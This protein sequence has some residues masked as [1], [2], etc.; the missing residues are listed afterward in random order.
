MELTWQAPGKGPWELET[1]HFQRPVTRIVETAF[2]YGFVKGFSEGTARYGLLLD[3]LE[4]ATVN[5]F[6]YNQPQAFGAPKGAAGPPPAPVLKVLTRLNPKMRARIAASDRAWHDR[7]WR[8]DLAQWD[9]V[10]RPAA[11]AVNRALQSVDP[12][13]LSDAELTAHVQRCADHLAQMHYLHHKYT[14]ASSVVS[15]DFVAGASEWTGASPGELLR[16][17]RG[18]SPISKGFASDELDV[19]A[20]AIGTH[21]A[22]RNILDSSAAPEAVL[23][24]LSADPDVGHDVRAYLEAVRFRS[25][26]YDVGDAT[27]GEL[28]DVLVGALRAAVEGSKASPE[29]DALLASLRE[30]VPAEHLADFDDRLGEARLMNRLRDERG[31]YSDGWATGLTRRALLEVGRRLVAAGRLE[32][33]EH[34]VELTAR[35][36]G[37]L[38]DGGTLPTA[39]EARDRFTWRTTRT[40]DDAPETLGGTPG[41]PPPAQLL[42]EPAR[43]PA[44]AM[45]AVLFNIFGVPDTPNTETVLT[46]LPVNPGEC[47]GVARVVDDAADFGRIQQGDILVARMTSPYFNVVLP[48]LGGI[49][50]DR[51]GQLCHAA[52][53]AREYGIPGV[54]GTRE[55]TQRIPDGSRVR[56]D[57]TT[58][59]VHLL[60]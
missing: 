44:K 13:G 55:A 57:G 25:L 53:V 4:P 58:G 36:C 42:P 2:N 21:P 10:D 54:V 38:L 48:M 30:R 34:A 16:L 37:T 17:L 47:E 51:G 5:Q 40:T 6:M 3:H 14:V 45:G 18:S 59:H 8:S 7:L 1:T 19:A 43:R 56:V 52:I 32:N 28:P 22:A 31:V 11:I 26:G 33:A 24:E 9:E 15:G 23:A 35:E 60:M 20:M 41:G 49:V 27:A 29:D 50:T 12:S 46:G 39:A